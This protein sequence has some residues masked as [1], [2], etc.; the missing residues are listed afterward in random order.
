[1]EVASVMFKG[2]LVHKRFFGWGGETRERKTKK[3]PI[4]IL[5]LN[6]IRKQ[7]LLNLDVANNVSE[8]S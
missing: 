3:G 6:N 1:M 2:F 7:L 5:G 4:H 8:K